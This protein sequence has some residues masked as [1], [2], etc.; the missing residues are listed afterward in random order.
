MLDY[1]EM[2]CLVVL[3]VISALCLLFGVAMMPSATFGIM[4]VGYA[5]G[6]WGTI[7][8]ISTCAFVFRSVF[9][10]VKARSQNEEE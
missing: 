1:D 6:I 2:E 5:I 7:G 4:L 10:S 8:V 9:L 3:F